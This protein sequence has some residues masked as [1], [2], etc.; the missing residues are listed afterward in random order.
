MAAQE[1]PPAPGLTGALVKIIDHLRRHPPLLYG[2]GAGILVIS[3]AVAAGGIAADQLWL[4]VLALVVLM[5]AGLGAW[6][7]VA[8]RPEPPPPPPRP[9]V[10]AGG[11][12]TAEDEGEVLVAKGAVPAGW[13][14]SIKAGRDVKASGKGKIGVSEET[15]SKEP[16]APP[17]SPEP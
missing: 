3:L 12:V 7:I 15:S 16:K 6:L 4:L 10:E 9:E 13:A 5:L 2:L 17:S 1:P 14:P 8:R 11:A